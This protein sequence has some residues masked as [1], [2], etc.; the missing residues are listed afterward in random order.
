MST[1]IEHELTKRALESILEVSSRSNPALIPFPCFASNM[2]NNFS[3]LWFVCKHGSNECFLD[4]D[5]SKCFCVASNMMKTCSFQC[6][7]CTL[8]GKFR[9]LCCHIDVENLLFLMHYVAHMLMIFGHFSSCVFAKFSSC[10]IKDVDQFL[11]QML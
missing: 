7:V 3:F 9:N 5:D 6:F 8:D 1:S 10:C 11:F 2:L 4:L